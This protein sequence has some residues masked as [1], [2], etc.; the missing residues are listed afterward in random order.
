[1]QAVTP[2]NGTAAVVI[3]GAK[4]TPY[5]YLTAGAAGVPPAVAGWFKV[6]NP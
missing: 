2:A 5:V 4:A 1:M 3:V 6:G